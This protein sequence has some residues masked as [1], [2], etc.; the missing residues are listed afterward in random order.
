MTT[1]ESKDEVKVLCLGM[2]RTGTV[3][4]RAAFEKLGY[5]GTYHYRV[6][7]LEEPSHSVFWEQALRKKHEQHGTVTRAEFDKVFGNYEA[8]T[9]APSVF[10]WRE[11]LGTYL[12][13]LRGALLTNKCRGI[14]KR[15]SHIA[16]A[17][18]GK[19]VQKPHEEHMGV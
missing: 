3:S 11:L 19:L 17:T 18:D 13:L 7:A 4:L 5:H 9:D 14:S 10:F 2:S 8:I 6:P 12:L 15:E 16:D 1:S